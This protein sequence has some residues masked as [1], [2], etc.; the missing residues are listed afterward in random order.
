MNSLDRYGEGSPITDTATVT[1]SDNF[2]KLHGVRA[3]RVQLPAQELGHS[4]S[5]K[6]VSVKASS[7]AHQQMTRESALLDKQLTSL[8]EKDAF[9]AV[10]HLSESRTG[11]LTTRNEN[12]PRTTP[13][14]VG[15]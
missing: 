15:F 12:S 8:L 7:G 9:E 4:E 14:R 11:S 1:E 10:E 2:T 6:T 13:G 5:Y 3:N